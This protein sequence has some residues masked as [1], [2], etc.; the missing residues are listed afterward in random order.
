V[1]E[2]LLDWLDRR[3][4]D[5]KAV[6]DGLSAGLAH[7]ELPALS[8][9]D[10]SLLR[11]AWEIAPEDQLAMQA[12]TQRY[13]DG[14]VSKTVHLDPETRPT[15][16]AIAAWIHRAR[17]LGCKGAA[18]FCH[19]TATTPERIDLRAPCSHACGG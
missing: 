11:R 8:Q 19:H 12:T 14:A 2:T 4:T 15:S 1:E 17:D 16:A 9:G 13:V 3:T 7:R 6:L 10:Q 18:F 5:A